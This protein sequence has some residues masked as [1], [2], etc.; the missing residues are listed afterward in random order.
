[1]YAKRAEEKIS[2]DKNTRMNIF[3]CVRNIRSSNY[4]QQNCSRFGEDKTPQIS[5]LLLR[6]K[7]KLFEFNLFKSF[8]ERNLILNHLI[9]SVSI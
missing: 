9:H 3:Q 6:F 4:L 8:I 5:L 7:I 1:M 2:T